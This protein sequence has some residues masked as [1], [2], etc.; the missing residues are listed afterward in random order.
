MF[1]R[2]YIGIGGVRGGFEGGIVVIG[3]ESVIALCEM[4]GG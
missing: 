4:E 3:H 2:V 1:G